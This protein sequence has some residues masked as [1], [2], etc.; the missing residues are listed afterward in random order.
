LPV[1]NVWTDAGSHDCE[2]FRRSFAACVITDA[3]G[4]VLLVHQIYGPRK[5][6]LPGG[7]LDSGEPPWECARRETRE[8]VGLEVG[9]L[10][11]TGV[12]FVAS[13][14]GFGF[15][16]RAKSYAGV[17]CPDG[18]EIGEA[19]FFAPDALPSPLSDFARERILDAVADGPKPLL[20]VQHRREC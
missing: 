5:W 7:V 14:D 10:E 18:V 4:R 6:D 2:S 9:E 8:E 12:Y 11:L 17:V 20:R 19:A 13:R 3:D 15:I 1:E 16:F